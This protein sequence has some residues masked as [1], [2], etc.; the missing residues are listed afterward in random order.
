MCQQYT[1]NQL[2]V[3]LQAKSKL[4]EIEI[5]DALKTLWT[6]IFMDHAALLFPQST[7]ENSTLRKTFHMCIQNA[8]FLGIDENR[9]E[10]HAQ[11]IPIKDTLTALLKDP[12]VWEECCRNESTP[13]VLN[14]VCDGLVFKS[15]QLFSEPGVTLKVILYQDAFEVVNPLGSAKICY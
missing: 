7:R 4:S 13:L 10:R 15:N 12:A 14:D 11:C 5:E 9:K 2:K 1:K 8:F 3:S 6:W